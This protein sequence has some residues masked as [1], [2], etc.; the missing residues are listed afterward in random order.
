MF[1]RNNLL[2]ILVVVCFFVSVLSSFGC[3]KKEPEAIKIGAILLLTGS[4]APYGQNAKCGI[5]LAL[6]FQICS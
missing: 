6:N 3:A 2:K 1:R 4:A 5:L